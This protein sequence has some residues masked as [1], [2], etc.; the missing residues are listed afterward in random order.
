MNGVLR[1]RY[2]LLAGSMILGSICIVLGHLLNVNSS[3][4]PAT[5]VRDISA[6]HAAFVAGSVILSAGAFLVIAAM[7]GAMRLAPQRG[8]ALVTTGAVL[9]CISAA[10][11]A[12]GTLMLGTVMGMLTPAH[13]A[14]AVQ[15]DQIASHSGIGSLPF[16]PAP[17]LLIGAL[18]VAIGLYR[19]RLAP[20]WPA[21]LLGISAIPV[22]VAP[23][24]GALGAVLHLR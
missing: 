11:L 6:H 24:G 13:A 8:G 20:R 16:I 12:A 2:A 18:L 19:A 21:I 15:V 17:G 3:L 1:T 14:L 23:S 9:A 22:A 7:A 5:Y 4:A 10:G